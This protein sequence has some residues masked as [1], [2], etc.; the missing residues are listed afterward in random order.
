MAFRLR[1]FTDEVPLVV[2]AVRAVRM[3]FRFRKLADERE[4]F[5]IAFV[6]MDVLW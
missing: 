2:V 6:R 5:R 4:R 3:A 1:E